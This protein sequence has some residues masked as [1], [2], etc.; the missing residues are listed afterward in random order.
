MFFYLALHRNS[1]FYFV[2]FG[3]VD[4]FVIFRNFVAYDFYLD[5]Y[6]FLFVPL[7]VSSVLYTSN[8]KLVAVACMGFFVLPTKIHDFFDYI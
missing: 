7:P 5:I 6:D 3:C 1:L 4:T 2:I 8:N